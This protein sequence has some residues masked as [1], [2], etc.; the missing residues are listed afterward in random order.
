VNGRPGTTA[1]DDVLS[2]ARQLREGGQCLRALRVLSEGAVTAE[3]DPV[4]T[5]E[6]V[7]LRHLA[8]ADLVLGPN[9]GSR[10]PGPIVRNGSD[11]GPLPEL[12]PDELDASSLR[13][14]LARHGCVLV[15]Q[16]ISEDR[17]GELCSGIDRA[18]ETLDAGL[19]GAPRH[20]T[21]PWYV[22][23]T[24]ASGDYRVGGRRKWM[25]ASGGMWTVDS[26]RMLF[27]LVRLFDELGM[28]PL[29]TE[30]FGEAP[31]LSANKCNLRRVPV[32]TATNWHQDGA[33]LG[34][35][36][37]SLN[38][39]LGLSACGTDAPGLDIVPRRLDEILQ[40]GTEGAIF[41]WSVSP[42]LVDALDLPVLTPQFRPGDALLFDH[43]FLHR[44]GVTSG[45]TKE[46]YAIE[47]WFFAPSSYP[48]GQIPIVY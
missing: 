20:E 18:L 19:A 25:R 27:E 48:D 22:P 7:Q 1:S 8:F 39:W 23:F 36:V 34:A 28:R 38:L 14:G 11:P 10:H 5:E 29:L 47:S 4:L 43:L 42:D 37:Q 3:P 40:T 13:R 32:D 6:L 26:P 46:R 44:T 15:R 35:D 17:A 2:R 31:A 9:D 45:M 33:F 12:S 30:F 16:L 41:D 24:P 21:T